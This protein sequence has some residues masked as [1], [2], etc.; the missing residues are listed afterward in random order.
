[1]HR[2]IKPANLFICRAADEVDVVKVLDFGLVRASTGELG[3][4]TLSD[5]AARGDTL[6]GKQLESLAPTELGITRAGGLMGTPLY[7]APE[8]A[9]GQPI[10]GRAD[11]YAL[12]CV[13]FYL[14][15]GRPVFSA[16]DTPMNIL[17]AHV[18]APAPDLRALVSGWL[19][20]ELERVLA[21]CLAK[22]PTNRP[23]SARALG[24]ALREIA[25]PPEHAW[26]ESAAQ[27]WWSVNHPRRRTIRPTTDPRQLTIV[28]TNP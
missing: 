20:V 11:L 16:D 14:L 12:G 22:E 27:D 23:S 2:D 26:T 15:T 18:T 6:S 5:S 28:D 1:V 13:A 9:L 4:I 19:P 8:Q 24:A 10:D 7:M 17:I 21:S 3:N 25:I